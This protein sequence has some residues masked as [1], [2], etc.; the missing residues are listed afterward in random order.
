MTRQDDLLA[1]AGNYARERGVPAPVVV[2]EILHYEILF[3]LIESG[4]ASA[5]AFQGET[6]LRLC[7]QGSRYSEDLDFVQT[8]K[9]A[10]G[11]LDRFSKLLTDRIADAYGLSVDIRSKS[12]A[13]PGVQVS[14]WTA[15]IDVP[16]PD[17]SSQQKQ[18]IHVEIASVPA[19]DIDVVSVVANYPHL[20]PPLRSMMLAVE[21]LDEILADK[22]LA[23]VARDYLKA[24]DVWDIK[25]LRDR[26]AALR[27][28]LL[29]RKLADYG[30]TA[31]GYIER[32]SERRALFDL[33]ETA[34]AYVQ[35]MSRFV[36]SSVSAS[37]TAVVK[38]HFA[39]SLKLLDE[40]ARALPHQSLSMG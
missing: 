38:K 19:H 36:P 10:P 3:A 9:L 15:R 25:F 14:R 23:L 24:R 39:Q 35:E 16:N 20:P 6:A 26:G 21:S 37:V 11:C 8:G 29:E 18:L 7:Y 13:G 30:W 32:L 22:A 31:G 5:L 12:G 34:R 17:R 2:K 4:A 28:D 33:P 40:A 27:P 1:L